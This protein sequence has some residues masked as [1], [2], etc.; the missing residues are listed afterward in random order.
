[1]ASRCGQASQQA[2]TP[3]DEEDQALLQRYASLSSVQAIAMAMLSDITASGKGRKHLMR[4][5]IPACHPHRQRG[6]MGQK[7]VAEMVS[8]VANKIKDHFT[9]S[10]LWHR[11][12]EWKGHIDHLIRQNEL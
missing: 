1:M 11:P 8:K 4:K 6:G 9:A 7:A 3:P 2:E 5:I 10:D 12:A